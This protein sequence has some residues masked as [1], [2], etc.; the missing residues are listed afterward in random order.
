VLR[1]PLKPKQRLEW[2]TPAFVAKRGSRAEC[3]GIHISRKTSEIPGFLYAAPDAT[4]GMLG[5]LL[6]ASFKAP[7]GS[8]GLPKSGR[9]LYFRCGGLLTVCSYG[10]EEQ[11]GNQRARA[12][13]KVTI[14]ETKT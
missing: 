1:I 8:E 6:S 11:A 10:Q 3:R 4:A 12:A 9:E 2:G 13:D 5:N 14:Q 7:L